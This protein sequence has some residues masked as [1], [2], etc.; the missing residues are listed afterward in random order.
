MRYAG[1]VGFATTVETSPGI[2]E[3]RIEERRYRGTVTIAAHR[4]TLADTTNSTLKAGAII[5]L[6]ADAKLLAQCFDIRWC[7]YGGVKWR[8][9]YISQKRPRVELTLGERYNE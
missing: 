6:I 3:E 8:P 5:S 9:T 2:W 1:K 4:V 7:E